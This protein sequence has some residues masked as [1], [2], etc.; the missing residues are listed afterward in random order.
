M[1]DID[2]SE[3]KIRRNL[4]LISSL[5]LALGFLGASEEAALQKILYP[6]FHVQT[7]KVL[8]LEFLLLTYFSLRYRFS[9][10]LSQ[11]L[12]DKRVEFDRLRLEQMMAYISN[13]LN[14]YISIGVDSPIFIPS[15]SRRIKKYIKNQGED[16][17]RSYRLGNLSFSLTRQINEWSGEIK[18]DVELNER[19]GVNQSIG[20]NLHVNYS[21]RG[22]PKCQVLI[23]TYLRIYL[24]SK[25][26]ISIFVPIFIATLAY[27]S[28]AYKYFMN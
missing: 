23:K 6:H 18:L 4:V 25:S 17:G 3:D 28:I 7:W 8:A 16:D 9:V 11:A 12:I 26:S 27:A 20:D 22:I 13:A 19:Q 21:F 15:L 2:D 1:P 24:Y 14:G 10:A 5:I